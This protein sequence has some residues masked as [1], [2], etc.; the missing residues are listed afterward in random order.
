[1]EYNDHRAYTEYLRDS[2]VEELGE[3]DM[4]QVDNRLIKY[5]NA[6]NKLDDLKD[7]YVEVMLKNDAERNTALEFVN[8]QKPVIKSLIELKSTLQSTLKAMRVTDH[9]TM[10]KQQQEREEEILNIKIESKKRLAEAE[11]RMNAAVQEDLIKLVQERQDTEK[12]F[13]DKNAHLGNNIATANAKPQVRLQKLSL[14]PFSGDVI[15]YVRF[16]A[17]FET[18]INKTQLDD[19]T[20][21]NYLLSLTKGK[22]RDD[23]SGLPHNA[24]GY[25]EAQRI[26][27]KKYGKDCVVF[28][29]LVLELENLPA[30]RH[31]HQKREINEFSQRFSKIV[32]TLK[33]MGKIASVD[34]N[35][36]SVFSR[37]GPLREN[38][39][40]TSDQWESWSLTK[41]AEELEKYVDRNNLSSDKGTSD[42]KTERRSHYNDYR[43]EQNNQYDNRRSEGRNQYKDKTFY[44]SDNKFRDNKMRCIFCNYTNHE[45][46]D[47]LKVLDLAKRR[48]II[49]TK[50]LCYVCLKGGHMASKC[51]AN[52]CSK[53]NR[54]H[55]I[56]ICDEERTTIPSKDESS[57]K[58]MT[59]I[60]KGT[61][62]STAIVD[63]NG[64]QA[65]VMVDTGSTRSHICTDLL[66]QLKIKPCKTEMC[67]MEQLYKGSVRKRIE[68]YKIK[69]RSMF[70]D[71]ELEIQANNT[72]KEIIT[73][74]KITTF[75]ILN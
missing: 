28:K 36:H 50:N 47:C 37:L 55:N 27:H 30:I 39:A 35:V 65:R 6:L 16:S 45:A 75:K 41:L 8:Q 70:S 10:L 61:I 69:I 62:H 53:C 64:I 34:G 46:K 5:E 74:L 2:I 40:A 20:K 21:L 48:D 73:Y 12:E 67:T 49:K 11:Q 44:N 22:P 33:T 25:A 9:R 15:D 59:S 63:I 71:F 19:V 14:T 1:M 32:R 4:S 68:I 3:L 13:Y 31:I 24:E 42:G 60:Q 52:L 54:R 66:Q 26:L 17:Q 72:D 43:P 18:E 58:V 51:K 57:E 56:V 29:S 7:K 23:I 38:L